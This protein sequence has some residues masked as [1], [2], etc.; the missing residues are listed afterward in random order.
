MLFT[1]S[2]GLSLRCGQAA[3]TTTQ[4]ALLC[5]DWPGG[6]VKA[7][8]F[9]AASDI[10]DD[11]NVS[12]LVVLLFACFGAGTPD[13]DQFLND[14]S[15]AGEAD[16]LAPQPFVAAL[17]QRLLTHPK[18]SALAVIG[19]IDR[20]WEFSIEGPASGPSQIKTFRDNI[21]LILQGKPVG[22]AVSG[23]FGARFATLSTALASAVSP[24]APAA[25][26]L[27]DLDLVTCWLERNDAQNYVLLGD[28]AVRIRQDL[29]TPAS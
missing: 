16:P 26:H 29:L 5:Q 22:Y 20:A 4:G 10:A 13:T 17:P 6:M 9:L 28:P 21:G 2:H 3:Q 23:E 25:S 18:G 19:H 24:S 15:Q 27:S 7:E 11:A 8:H 14:L 1:A 12:G